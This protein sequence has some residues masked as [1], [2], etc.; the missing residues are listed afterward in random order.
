MRARL[1]RWC[2]GLTVAGGSTALLAHHSIS[3]VEIAAPEWVKGTVT[4][5]HMRD[6]HVMLK[7]EVKGKGGALEVWDIEGPNMNRLR[8]MGAGKDF[9]KVGD[10]IEVCGFHLKQPW[11]K[12]DFVHGQVLVMPD[13]H[14]R[15]FGPYGRME[16]CIRPGDSAEKWT[17]FLQADPLAM[18]AWCD[19]HKY[20][21]VASVAPAGFV[22]DVDRLMGNPCR[23]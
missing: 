11:Y 16:N 8:R 7:L 9:L 19:S 5:Y 4:E 21:R 3:V 2:I 6:P 17:G 13:G 12:A 10:V 23:L 14:M 22:A 15:T 1:A 18:P 20:V